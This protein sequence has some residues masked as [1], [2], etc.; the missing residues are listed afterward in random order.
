M[1]VNKRFSNRYQFFAN[2]TWSQELAPML[3]E[4]ERD[5]ET[6]YGPQDPFNLN[7]DYG[8]DGLDITHQVKRA[9]WSSISRWPSPGAATSSSIAASLTLL[10]PQWTLTATASSINSPTMTG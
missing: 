1:G 10:I 4:L 2:Y 7:L 6:F 8:R 3:A 5:T 9:A